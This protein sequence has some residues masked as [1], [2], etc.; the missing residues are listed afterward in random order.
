MM[1]DQTNSAV[2]DATTGLRHAVPRTQSWDILSNSQLPLPDFRGPLLTQY[3]MRAD[4]TAMLFSGCR[5][6]A[7]RG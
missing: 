4:Q 5:G 6:A 1:S 3:S 7:E 2:P